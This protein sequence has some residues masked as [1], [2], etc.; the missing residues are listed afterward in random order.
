ME[1]Q[2]REG[3]ADGP[4]IHNR[5]PRDTVHDAAI[6][7]WMATRRAS[8][9]VCQIVQVLDLRE[10]ERAYSGRGEQHARYHARNSPA[11]QDSIEERG[12]IASVFHKQMYSYKHGFLTVLEQPL[13]RF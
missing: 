2:G 13:E 9:A 6:N 1:E 7:Q 8:C 3:G 5:G 10:I 12:F 4:E 11:P